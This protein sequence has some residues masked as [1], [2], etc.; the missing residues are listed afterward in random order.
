MYEYLFT[1]S[2]VVRAMKLSVVAKREHIAP[3]VIIAR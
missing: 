2:H 1:W 3:F